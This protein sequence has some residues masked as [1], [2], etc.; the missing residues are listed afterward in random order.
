MGKRSAI[1]ITGPDKGGTAAWIFTSLSVWMA[2][3]RPIRLR[4]HKPRS[5]FE[6]DGL[7]IGGGADIDPEAYE[8]ADFINQYLNRTLRNKD[9]TVWRR[10]T[11]FIRRLS[12]PFIFLTRRL[13]SMK[14]TSSIDKERDELEFNVLDRAIKKDIPVLGICRGSQLI[15]IYFNGN[16]Y[17]DIQEHYEEHVNRHSI[18]PIIKVYIK[19]NSRLSGILKMENLWVNAM[20]HQAVRDTGKHLQVVGWELSGIVQAIESTAHNFVIGV[21]WHPEY[22]LERKS[23]R[24][25][26]K[27]LVIEAESAKM[28]IVDN[29]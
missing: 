19:P 1:G 3:G 22:L 25:I 8:K 12:Y 14:S 6:I 7:I 27:A 13:L 2:G 26:F 23:Q 10:V 16:L 5:N 4:P 11:T 24:R 29:S 17:N 28:K 9:I 15:N 21:Q 20:H 18:F